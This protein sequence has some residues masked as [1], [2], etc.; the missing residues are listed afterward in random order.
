MEGDAR[1]HASMN[2]LY[3]GLEDFG[4]GGSGGYTTLYDP[5]LHHTV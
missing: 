3:G 5:Y 1:H 4:G 2:K